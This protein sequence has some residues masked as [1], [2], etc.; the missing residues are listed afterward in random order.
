MVTLRTRRTRRLPPAVAPLAALAAGGAGAV[1]LYG[2]DPHDPG[3]LL[4]RC[5][6]NWLTGLDCPGCGGTRMAYDLLH[7]DLAAAFAD[8]AALLTLGV[9][10]AA[11]LGGRWLLEGLRGRRYRPALGTRA[12]IAVVALAVAWTVLRNVTGQP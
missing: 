8:N 7:G 10:A 4:P 3:Q 9:P 6:V 11:Y 1:Y 5:P 2:T 12:T